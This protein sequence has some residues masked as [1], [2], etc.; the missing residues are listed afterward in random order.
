MPARRVLISIDEQLLARI[1]RAASRKGM[2]RSGYL[3]ELAERDIGPGSGPGADPVV[4]AA[5]RALD[6]LYAAAPAIDAGAAIASIRR[7]T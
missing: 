3:A 6:D 4:R 2:S 7:R 1:D 5:M